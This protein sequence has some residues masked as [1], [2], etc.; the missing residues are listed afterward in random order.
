MCLRWNSITDTG[1]CLTQRCRFNKK[2]MWSPFFLRVV[3]YKF[4]HFG[5][6]HMSMT[7]VLYRHWTTPRAEPWLLNNEPQHCCVCHISWSFR[8]WEPHWKWSSLEEKNNTY[9]HKRWLQ[10]LTPV[11]PLPDEQNMTIKIFFFN[12]A[13]KLPYL[14]EKGSTN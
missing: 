10:A 14:M 2:I 6:T 3:Y 4:V 8:P 5:E 13:C 11:M 7:N 12:E 1:N 9:S